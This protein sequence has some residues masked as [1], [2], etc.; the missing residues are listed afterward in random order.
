MF[1]HLNWSCYQTNYRLSVEK[2]AIVLHISKDTCQPITCIKAK[3][4]I[5]K[6]RLYPFWFPCQNQPFLH[7]ISCSDDFQIYEIRSNYVTC[8]SATLN[9]ITHSTSL[10]FITFVRSCSEKTWRMVKLHLWNFWSF[11]HSVIWQKK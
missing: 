10:L 5:R 11:L 4:I 6:I 8:I 7:L 1:D 9:N 2:I 3:E